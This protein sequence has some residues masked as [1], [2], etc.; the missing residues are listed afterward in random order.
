[1]F[2]LL[3]IARSTTCHTLPEKK[4]TFK[5]ESITDGHKP[6]AVYSGLDS[7]A[8]GRLKTIAAKR[9]H[10]SYDNA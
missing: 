5:P 10:D 2:G 6:L 4:R 1:M 9:K 7:Q 3:A 8:N